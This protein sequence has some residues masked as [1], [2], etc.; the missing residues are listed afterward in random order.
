MD[1]RTIGHE[2]QDQVLAAARKGRQRV[3]STVRTVTATAQLIRPQ[4]PSL[5]RP[6]LGLPTPAGLREK[7]PGL[8]AKLPTPDQIREKAK[9]PTPDQIREKMAKLPA[10]DQIRERV[11]KLPTPDQIRSG[12]HEFA[13]QVRFVQ[14]LVTDQ[15][16]AVAE[17]LMHQASAVLTP[18]ASRTA[19]EPTPE[20]AA[21]PEAEPTAKPASAGGTAESE[22]AA[23]DAAT[24]AQEQ[25]PASGEPARPAART[26]KTSAA[27][28]DSAKADSAKASSPAKRTS[29]SSRRAPSGAAKPKTKPADK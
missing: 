28:A 25:K 7:A 16:R 23:A 11:A 17:P 14:R 20:P 27:K 18:D 22:G 4:L 5:P 24:A 19:T 26:A 2:L 13:G 3:T 1:S 10:S 21:E 6:P 15:V 12:A 8:V 29:T 9:L